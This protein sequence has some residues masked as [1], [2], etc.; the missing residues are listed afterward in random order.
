MP[1]NVLEKNRIS[2]LSH[3]KE[4]KIRQLSLLDAIAIVIPDTDYFDLIALHAL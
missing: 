1:V 3:P 2:L 4:V